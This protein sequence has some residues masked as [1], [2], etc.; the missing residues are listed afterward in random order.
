MDMTIMLYS[1]NVITWLLLSTSDA[2]NIKHTDLHVLGEVFCNPTQWVVNATTDK[3]AGCL[4]FSMVQLQC[5]CVCVCVWCSRRMQHVKVLHQDVYSWCYTWKQ[6]IGR[7]RTKDVHYTS[8]IHL[9]KH[10]DECEVHCLWCCY[11]YKST[12][13]VYL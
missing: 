9:R 10:I 2:L 1:V 3:Y 6:Y 12:S 11:Y 4:P 7:H 8:C 13:V 5:V